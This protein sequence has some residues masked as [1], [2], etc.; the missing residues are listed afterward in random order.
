M[1]VFTGAFT[2]Y[3]FATL[4]E[5]QVFG[6][7]LFRVGYRFLMAN[8]KA[9]FSCLFVVLQQHNVAYKVQRYTSL[10]L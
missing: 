2:H 1:P 4:R 6:S 7:S 3:C 10:L 5:A 8:D 9:L